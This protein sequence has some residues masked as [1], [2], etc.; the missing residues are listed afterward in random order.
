MR[1]QEISNSLT[2]KRREGGVNGDDSSSKKQHLKHGTSE[3][4]KVEYLKTG[5]DFVVCVKSSLHL[6]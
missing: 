3:T 1:L 5:Q 2:K 6:P 4:Q